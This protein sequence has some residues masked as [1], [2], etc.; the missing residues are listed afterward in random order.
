MA[1]SFSG[2]RS[3]STQREPLTMGKQLVNFISVKLLHEQFLDILLT[4]ILLFLN[5]VRELWEFIRA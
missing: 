2:G 5:G 4:P 3:Q 1:T